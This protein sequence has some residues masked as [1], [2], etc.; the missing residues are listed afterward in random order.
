MSYWIYSYN[1]FANII[2]HLILLNSPERE[3]G[4]VSFL[5]QI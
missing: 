4:L 5:V 3:A 1:A 2:A